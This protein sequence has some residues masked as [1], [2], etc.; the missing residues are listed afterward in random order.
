MKNAST[1]PWIVLKF[2]GTSVASPQ[3]WN[4][5]REIV[6][7]RLGE[8]L[9]PVIVCS[10]LAGISDK[11]EQLLSDALT[12][13]HAPVLESIA[14]Q[15]RMLAGELDVPVGD[16][17]PHLE[18][19]SNLA[20][21]IA[22]TREASPRTH[23]RVMA[24]GELMSTRLGAAFLNKGAVP[25]AWHDARELLTTDGTYHNSVRAF[26]SAS[27]A[28]ENDAEVKGTLASSPQPA[29]I[30][31]GFIARNAEGDTVLLG[32]GGSDVSASYFAA[33]LG[34]Q[35]F[36]MWTD[37]PGMYT[38]NPR[39]LPTARL[40]KSLGYDEAQEIASTGAKV[41]HPRCISP[42]RHHRIPLHIK[43][44]S[45]P[46]CEGTV[47]TSGAASA[48]AQVKAISSKPGV[49]IV[50][51]E[52]IDM[53][54]QSGFLADAFACFKKHGLSVDLVSTSETN[55]T[56]TL[57]RTTNALD[58][59]SLKG[60]TASLEEFCEVR[61]IENC[62]FVSL[63]GKNIRSILHQLGS[64][65]EVFEEQK[66]Y[67]VTQASNDLNLTFVVDEDQAERLVHKLHSELF[68]RRTHD[69]VLGST[70]R[71][72][73][74]KSKSKAQERPTPWWDRRADELI[75]L[76]KEKS[77]R[78]VYD[79]GTIHRSIERLA[80]LN[81]VDRAFYST[82]ANPHPEIM[83][84]IREADFGFECVSPGE[85]DHVFKLFPD[86]DPGRIMFTPNFASRSDYE[87]GLKRGVI[88]TLDNLFPLEAWPELF[89][90]RDVFVRMDPGRGKGHHKYVHTAGTKSKF[91][92]PSTQI[93]EFAALADTCGARVVGLH[94][95]VGSSIFEPDTWSETALYL[96]E[97]AKRFPHV[98]ALD[99]GGGLGVV[100]KPGQDEIDLKAVNEN[101]RNFKA[102][103]PQFKLWI[104][105][106]RYVVAEAGVLLAKV[107][108]TKRKGEYC[109][110]G[111]DAG[112]NALIRPAL[113]GSYH[114]IV[115][116][117]RLNEPHTM[118]ANI[119]GP[120]CETGD[121]LGNARSIAPPQEG[122][123][124]LIATAGAYGSVMSSSYNL[125]E[126]AGEHFLP[127]CG[128]S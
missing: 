112:M 1:N 53:W 124:M 36:E 3:K 73:F 78:Y 31:Q 12:G 119:V 58:S 37:V 121:V 47:V 104:E 19:L 76:A 23:A 9:R 95:H 33:K 93:D 79:E 57:D 116:L 118:V 25:T 113:Y 94:A 38:A 99:L 46:H 125:R 123:V 32:R 108:Q 28:Y 48:S 22:L 6:T 92:V 126:P 59:T 7:E 84:T 98:T 74:D 54:H 117:S 42:L 85:V 90:D 86:I 71:E 114:E 10:A 20:Q 89:R 128:C 120:I 60:L 24:T 2:G 18:E 29:I 15:H 101:L 13:N 96:A 8:G 26:L 127:I 80:E 81:E 110:V 72:Q 49:T 100:E 88:V 55:V 14:E 30:T 34:A 103:F 68:S 82:K 27:C 61:V 56:V 105:P 62:A 51:L 87:R 17:A 122:D 70:W 67:L 5:I 109:Y 50:S 77:P 65:L 115:N 106:G 91:G 40:I 11:L 64:A 41:I 45:D 52:T 16:I 44:M 102:A 4:T 39:Q 111:I 35:R 83:R 107:T 21:G 63:V 75:A 66:I 43:C 69:A 97:V